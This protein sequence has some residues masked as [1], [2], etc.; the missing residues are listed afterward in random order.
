MSILSLSLRL[1]YNGIKI[2]ISISVREQIAF[3]LFFEGKKTIFLGVF[4]L[5]NWLFLGDIISDVYPVF[6]HL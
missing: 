3:L 1:V 6:L 2:H 5:N 4:R